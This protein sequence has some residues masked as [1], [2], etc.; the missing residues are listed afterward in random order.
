M[1]HKHHHPGFGSGW[2]SPAK[3]ALYFFLGIA[4]FFLITEHL[5]HLIS[6]LP[7]LLLLL[8]LSVNAPI[9]ARWTWRTQ[10]T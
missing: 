2:F 1:V 7:W 5:A 6:V 9:Y 4:A 10:R 3:I 8:C